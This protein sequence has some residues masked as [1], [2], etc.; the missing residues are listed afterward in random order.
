M[1]DVASVVFRPTRFG[2]GY[3]MAEVD[4]FLDELAAGLPD[5]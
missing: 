5:Q 4:D 1:P 3:D 2:E